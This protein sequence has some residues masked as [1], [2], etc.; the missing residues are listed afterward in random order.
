M[1]FTAIL[2]GWKKERTFAAVKTFKEYLPDDLFGLIPVFEY[3]LWA[4]DLRL[5]ASKLEG[6]FKAN[7]SLIK[8]RTKELKL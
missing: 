1:V 4:A 5:S 3:Q 2:P 7:S 6:F 8:N